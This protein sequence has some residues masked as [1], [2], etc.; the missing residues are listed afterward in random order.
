MAKIIVDVMGGDYGHKIIIDGVFEALKVIDDEIIFV[1]AENLIKEVVNTY[2]FKNDLKKRISIVNSNQ[3]I[4]MEDSP[5]ES[6]RKKPA[7]SMAIGLD[8]M[9]E[10]KADAFLSAGN[11]GAMMVTAMKKLDLIEGIERPAIGALLP[12][13]NNEA[14]LL[15]DAGANVD[16]KPKHLLQF[17][18]MGSIF[19]EYIFEKSKPAVGLLNIGTEK[20]KG[21]ELTK[22][23]FELLEKSNLNFI[24]NIE[25]RDVFKGQTNVVV[26]DGFVGNIVLKISEQ[27]A[28]TITQFLKE[29]LLSNFRSKIGALLVSSELKKLKKRISYDEYGGAPLLGIN[30][31]CIKCHGSSNAK[32]VKSAVITSSKYIK[33]DLN[34]ILRKELFR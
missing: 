9:K 3:F 21:T 22:S 20:N 14:T 29:S 25:G 11:T 33:N 18:L 26:C 17:A 7:S 16:C 5:I 28:L 34:G 13:A 6:M 32:A 12:N 4:T 27:L 1:G 30:G 19:Y 8:L 15:I 31:C 23:T 2:Y 24:G 10:K